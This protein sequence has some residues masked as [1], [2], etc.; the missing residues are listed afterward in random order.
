MQVNR[1]GKKREEEEIKE[2]NKFRNGEIRLG[3]GQK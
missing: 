1:D 3:K 2:R